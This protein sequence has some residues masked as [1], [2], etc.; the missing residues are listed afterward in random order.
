VERFLWN[1][2][3][4]LSWKWAARSWVWW[5]IN[6]WSSWYENRSTFMIISN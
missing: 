1:F 5:K 3:W 2:V 4:P 6:I